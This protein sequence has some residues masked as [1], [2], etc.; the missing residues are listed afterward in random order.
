M[1]DN[2]A[3]TDE[4]I[5][6]Q[7]GVARALELLGEPVDNW[8]PPRAGI[9]HD[10]VIIGAGQSGLAIAFALKRKGIRNLSLIDAGAAGQEGPWR[11]PARMLT[12]RSPKD[13]VGPELG[14]AQLTF[15]AWYQ[16]GF[17]E[18]AYRGLGKIPKDTWMDYLNWY[19]QM[20]DVDVANRVTLSHI[21]PLNPNAP[22]VS[23]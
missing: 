16:A 20:I 2:A 21:K 19:R 1:K 5:E 13:L 8:V 3:L 11:T 14:I 15:R 23:S 12:L 10:I 7:T 18:A 4:L 22:T 17:G 9:D 6:L